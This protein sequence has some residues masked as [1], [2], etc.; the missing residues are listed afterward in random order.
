[1]T[2]RPVSAVEVSAAAQPSSP[3]ET[4]PGGCGRFGWRSSRRL[5]ASVRQERIELDAG[6]R[7]VGGIARARQLVDVH[8]LGAVPCQDVE[9]PLLVLSAAHVHPQQQPAVIELLLE[10]LGVVAA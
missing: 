6:Q 7:I 8:V 5:D 2:Q 9:R 3:A 1:M 10:R 4:R